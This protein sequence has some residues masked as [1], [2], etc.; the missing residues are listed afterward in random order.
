M[1]FFK[2]LLIKKNLLN[3][4][5]F[6]WNSEKKT[7]NPIQ[8]INTI[9]LNLIVCIERQKKTLLENTKNFSLGNFTN[10]ALLWGARGNGKST[11]IKSIFVTLSIE[12]KNLE[13]DALGECSIF[14][15]LYS[16][17]FSKQYFF[18]FHYLKKQL[19]CNL[20]T[21]LDVK[22]LTFLQYYQKH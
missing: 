20:I 7:I 8:K 14:I 1:V 6:I 11:L 19:F 13:Y 10:N 12:Y 22:H 4:H 5:A 15:C 17:L 9:N 16:I 2:H 18:I 3:N 21:K